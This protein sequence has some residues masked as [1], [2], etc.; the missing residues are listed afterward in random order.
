MYKYEEVYQH[1]LDYFNSDHLAT[2]IWIDKYCLKDNQGNLY[3][4]TPWDM[5][6]RLAKEFARIESKYKNPL[7]EDEIFGLLDDF[8]YL[9]PQ[10]SPMAGIGNDYLITSLSNCFVVDSPYDSYSGIFKTEQQMVAIMK[11]RGGVGLSIDSLRPKN[12]PT[13]SVSKKS[14]G[15][16]LFSERYSNATREVAQDGRR[17]ALMLSCRVDHPDI[18]DFIEAKTD[19][20]KITGA[21]VSIMITDEFMDA[22]TAGSTYEVYFENEKGWT[23]EDFD[24]KEVWNLIIKNAW[25]SAEPGVLFWD[26]ILRES[27]ANGYGVEWV[28]TSTNPCGEIP[29]CPYDSCRLMAINLFSYVKYKFTS[30]A[31]FDADLFIEHVIK[32][33]RIMDDL[34]DLEIEKIDQIIDKIEKEFDP[35]DLKVVELQ[36]WTKIRKKAVEGRRTGLGITAMGDMLAAM[37]L[38]YGTKE[39]TDFAENV[40]QAL[41]RASFTSSVILAQ[42]RSSFP[43]WDKEKEQNNPYITRILKSF[44]KDSEKPVYDIEDIALL[45]SYYKY[46]RRN[47][48]SLTIA[49]TGTVSILTQTTSGIEPV[50]LPIYKRRRKVN[51]PD[52]AVFTDDK[53][54]MWEEYNVFH[55]KFVEWYIIESQC[56][57]CPE[58][59]IEALE[60]ASVEDLEKIVEL[61]PY[62][63][64]CSNDVDWVEKVRMQGKLQK[65]IDHSISVTVNIPKETD[66]ET[67]EM[68][69]KTAYESGCKGI[70]IYRDGSRTGVMVSG[71]DGAIIYHDSPKRPKT[72]DCDIYHISR[73][74]E[75]FTVLVGK[76]GDKPYE[77]FVI[78]QL[79]NFEFCKK[80]EKGTITKVKKGLYKLKGTHGE[81]EYTI[82]DIVSRLEEDE[83]KQTRNFSTMLRHGI[84][85]VHIVDQIESYATI[86][87]FDRV[88]AKALRNYINGEKS[89][90]TCDKCGNG[91]RY[92]EGCLKCASCGFNKCG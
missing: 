48:S 20:N 24:A 89:K 14:S 10:G 67:V 51:D 33:Q 17:G 44:S 60:N 41:A 34:V 46:G 74:G 37:G 31:E 43:I 83:R 9:I 23:S 12:I 30:K 58:L 62:Y 91:L 86:S 57:H 73:G 53:G 90:L 3:E 45:D 40:I 77:I 61:S 19:K 64:A 26:T 21:N 50:F 52:L 11:R 85:P 22:V 27:V 71:D 6:K 29:L 54:D 76:L 78:N 5:H 28:E 66:I 79:E 81:K 56:S 80:I 2:T 63:N 16:V 87:A 36:M 92:E 25:K 72:L 59:A 75:P 88:T 38:T 49:P 7:K 1:T 82:E 15:I 13:S 39:A 69:Y 65:W 42:E 70:T 68:I 4:K 8:K 18:I 47:I 84:S 55:H 32:F 35:E